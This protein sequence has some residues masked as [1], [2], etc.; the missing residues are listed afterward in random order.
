MHVCTLCSRSGMRKDTSAGHVQGAV[1]NGVISTEPA[2]C[3]CL[4]DSS[5]CYEKK[6]DD[7][8]DKWRATYTHSTA[9]TLH[10]VTMDIG[11]SLHVPLCV[12]SSNRTSVGTSL[13]YTDW[14]RLSG[15]ICGKRGW[16]RLHCTSRQW[17]LAVHYMYRCVLTAATGR[18]LGHHSHT[19]IGTGCLDW[20]VEKGV[21][22]GYTAH[23]DNGYW[24]FITCTA[25]C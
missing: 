1:T 12:N 8:A 7:R 14:N 16:R 18:R 20:F 9:I 3:I 17:I 23:R 24:L 11:C 6:T 10:I 21:E 4:Q 2:S 15:L 25:V 19:L 13:T 5:R 22:G